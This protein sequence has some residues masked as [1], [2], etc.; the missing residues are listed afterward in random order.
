MTMTDHEQCGG[1]KPKAPADTVSHPPEST[2][3]DETV[4]ALADAYHH[5]VDHIMSNQYGPDWADRGDLPDEAYTTEIIFG[6]WLSD[7]LDHIDSTAN[8]R[9]L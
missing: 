1:A 3:Y 5:T 9:L 8:R 4:A 6:Q 7:L 2:A